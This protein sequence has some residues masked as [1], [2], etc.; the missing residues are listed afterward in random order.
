[1]KNKLL[2]IIILGMFLFNLIVISSSLPPV[3]QYDCV[4]I[5]TILN[6]TEVNISTITYP[7]QT[8]LFLDE[9]MTANGK[10]FNY[11]FCETD[12][13]GNY[14]Y[15]YYDLEGNVYVNDFEVTPSGQ[16]MDS[17]KGLTLIVSVIVM[18]IISL[19]F[20]FIANQSENIGAK[21]SFYSLSAITFI[22]SILYTVVVMQQTLFGFDSIISGIETF[23]F[24]IKML[25]GVGIFALL[26][27]VILILVK[28]WKIKRGYRD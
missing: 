10:T 13:L 27:I 19:V 6:T 14:L 23:W 3:K 12:V 24:V 9:S 2:I 4:E 26:I 21:V 8:T 18:I 17:S 5:K 25:I 15:D 7:N 20:L 28:A 1:M 16:S 22:M 11:T